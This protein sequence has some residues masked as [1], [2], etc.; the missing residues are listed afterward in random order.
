MDHSETKRALQAYS[1][2]D[3]WKMIALGAVFFLIYATAYL[4]DTSLPVWVNIIF[5]VMG[6]LLVWQGIA[7]Y[8]GFSKQIRKLEAMHTVPDVYTDFAQSSV[9]IGDRLRLGKRYLFGKNTGHIFEFGEI[10]RVYQY[11]HKTNGVEDR[12]ELKVKTTRGKELILCRLPL[13]GKADEDIMNVAAIIKAVNPA[14]EIG[15]KK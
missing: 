9:M 3:G 15:Y 4:V 5:L 7:A 8:T 14:V 6:I 10:S 13:K 12:R 11:I 2:P 1:R